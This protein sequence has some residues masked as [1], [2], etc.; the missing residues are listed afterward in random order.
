MKNFRKLVVVAG[1]A[2]AALASI[3]SIA[4]AQEG[5]KKSKLSTVKLDTEA[6]KL[7]YTFGAQ[8]GGQLAGSGLSGDVDIDAVVAAIRDVV[9]GNEP[10]MT[11]EEMQQTQAVYQQKAQAELAA[12]AAENQA[13]GDEYLAINGKAEGVVTG[14]SGLQYT[15]EREG[16]GKQP[17]AEDTVKVHYAG[18]LIDGTEFDSSYKRGA[19]ADFPVSGVIPGF[20]EGLQL[21]KE[22]AK[23]RFVIPAAQAYGEQGPPSIG[24]NQVLIF[25]V[26]LIEVL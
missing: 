21:M 1:V 18:T 14:E 15:V 6:S 11:I 7:G 13:K 24:P 26:E 25:D 3:S 19:P 22:G 20:S 12:I 4:V 2:I 8:I 16:K 5:A 10:R 9:G 17:T 23:Y